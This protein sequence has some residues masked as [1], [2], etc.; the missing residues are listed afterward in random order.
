M[1]DV[2]A[3]TEIAGEIDETSVNSHPKAGSEREKVYPQSVAAGA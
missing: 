1:G 2:E 3:M